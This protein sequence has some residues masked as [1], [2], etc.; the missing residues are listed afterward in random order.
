MAA[1]PATKPANG[2]RTPLY[3]GLFL[4]VAVLSIAGLRWMHGQSA[5]APGQNAPASQSSG[6]DDAPNE[7]NAPSQ[8]TNNVPPPGGGNG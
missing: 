2:S 3:V 8:D 1:S 4:V 7:A 5:P 6:D